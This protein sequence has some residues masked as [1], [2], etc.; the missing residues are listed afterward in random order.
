MCTLFFGHDDGRSWLRIIGEVDLETAPQVEAALESLDQP[1]EVECGEIDFIDCAG[2]GVL[3][4]AAASLG[5]VTL[6]DSSPLLVRMLQITGLDDRFRIERP[7]V[8]CRH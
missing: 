2:L 7:Q 1:L 5:S 4:R 6:R 8:G 3:A